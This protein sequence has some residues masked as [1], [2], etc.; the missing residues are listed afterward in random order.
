MPW[1]KASL[2]MILLCEVFR[3]PSGM[4]PT[5]IPEVELSLTEDRLVLT[6]AQVPGSICVLDN[7]GP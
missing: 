4:V 2:W 6:V 3:N 5:D 7:M 1:Q